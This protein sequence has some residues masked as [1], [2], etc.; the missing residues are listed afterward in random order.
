MVHIHRASGVA[1]VE[2][3]LVMLVVLLVPCAVM[4]CYPLILSQWG[5]VPLLTGYGT[6]M[7][8]FML[9]ACLLSIGLFVSSITESQVAAAVITLGIVIWIRRKRR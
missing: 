5:N 3:W 9:G 2:K 8:F 7:A 6:L 1:C 4:A